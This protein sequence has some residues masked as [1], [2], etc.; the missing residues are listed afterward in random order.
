MQEDC[1]KRESG[2]V[3]LF[4]GNKTRLRG[5]RHCLN[6]SHGCVS[7]SNLQHFCDGLSVFKA[8]QKHY[9]SNQSSLL[10]PFYPW[11]NT[12]IPCCTPRILVCG[13]RTRGGRAR[14]TGGRTGSTCSVGGW[15]SG[16]A[17]SSWGPGCESGRVAARAVSRGYLLRPHS[18]FR[19]RSRAPHSLFSAPPRAASESLPSSAAPARRISP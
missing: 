18:Q 17:R 14:L 3:R 4:G 9:A 6:L 12:T 10:R 11:S 5:S 13:R 2:D 7:K 8:N 15:P 1:S 16:P 19:R